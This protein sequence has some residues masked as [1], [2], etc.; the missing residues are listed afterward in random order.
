MKKTLFLLPAALLCLAALVACNKEKGQGDDALSYS[1]SLS[2]T[3]ITLSE[4]G[5]CHLKVDYSPVGKAKVVWISSN[6]NVVSVSED[7]LVKA[8]VGEGEQTIQANLISLV[9]YQFKAKAICTVKL[10]TRYSAKLNRK[11]VT[12]EQN[13]TCQLALTRTPED[14]TEIVWKSSF[15]AAVSVSQ[16]GL[17]TAV[18]Q[19]D[20]EECVWA[21]VYSKGD[22]QLKAADTCWV[23]IH[24][25]LVQNLIL[26]VE[27]PKVFVLKVGTDYQLN[28]I[29]EPEEAKDVPLVY[30][31]N[32]EAHKEYVTV[33]ETGLLHPIKKCPS[34]V[35]PELD[36]M[37]TRNKRHFRMLLNVDDAD[38][39][40]TAI[41]LT[42]MK[43]E[44]T[45][46][47]SFE[48]TMNYEPAS[49]TVKS[50]TATSSNTTVATVVKTTN[51][52]RVSPKAA[53]STTITVEYATSQSAKKT[54]TWTLAVH[55]GEPSIAWNNP[56]S[57]L[58]EG[59]I[60]GDTF[61][62]AATV[63]N[64]TNTNVV[65]SVSNSGVAS[66]DGNGKI[67]AL[68]AGTVKIY[69]KSEADPSLYLTKT[70][71]VYNKPSILS[72][73][74]GTGQAF[75]RFGGSYLLTFQ[76]RDSGGAPCRQTSRDYS[77]ITSGVPSSMS[78][79][80]KVDGGYIKVTLT[81]NRTSATE[82]LKGSLI[83]R[84][85][86]DNTVSQTVTVYDAMYDA[87]DVKPFDA[88]HFS[89]NGNNY[90]VVDGGF[91][92]SGYFERIPTTFKSRYGDDCF[93]L[94]VWV[95]QHKTTKN[96]I[97]KS[98]YGLDNGRAEVH[99]SAVYCRDLG[100]EQWWSVSPKNDRDAVFYSSQY[101]SY[102]PDGV[103]SDGPETDDNGTRGWDISAAMKYYNHHANSSKWRVLP[104]LCIEDNAPQLAD[105]PFHGGWYLPTSG[106]WYRMLTCLGGDLTKEQTRVKINEWLN[107]MSGAVP[108]NGSS[109]YW[110]CQEAEDNPLQEAVYMLG[111]DATESGKKP[112]RT[113]DKHEN[114]H[115][116]PFIAF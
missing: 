40:P 97:L 18:W 16:K 7:G 55:A 74:G 5:E 10:N 65:Y 100:T 61:T 101:W 46:G 51:G 21:E 103:Y 8:L 56:S 109:A 115:V 52:F 1:L 27:Y 73:T 83:V 11:A 102:W 81:S 108:I 41:S 98:L 94:I 12:L 15:P 49:S 62:E 28:P 79:S 111:N 88:V 63:G 13:E 92:G 20:C 72:L 59:L 80:T 9:D 32:N 85:K 4:A 58:T 89:E 87:C 38:I 107:K 68:S 76:L 44:C 116:R 47:S 45:K 93:A 112:A 2:E 69:A 95:G 64:L 84:S 25:P 30:T 86:A 54:K 48:V 22:G 105:S 70:F 6:P 43:S 66:V 99:G 3:E 24:T 106:E 90:D 34:S 78:V 113:A 29:I 71:T 33:S 39:Y 96:S 75:V 42:G 104:I 36:I 110:S 17:V 67:T 77:V 50:Y 26:P 37:A 35:N 53:G 114:Y 91:R 82:T 14:V 60:V 23:S 57:L 19:K 31:I